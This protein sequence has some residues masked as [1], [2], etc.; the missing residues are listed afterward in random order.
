MAAGELKR[1]TYKKH[2]TKFM[3]KKTNKLFNNS[4][5]IL[6][7][8]IEITDRKGR[9]C[10]EK[11]F[12]QIKNSRN[13][14][15]IYLEADDKRLGNKQEIF[16]A[17]YIFLALADAIYKNKAISNSL[18]RKELSPEYLFHFAGH[19]FREIGQ[20]NRA[21]DAYLRSGLIGVTNP[22]PSQLA[23]RSFARAKMLFS[24]VGENDKSDELHRME[25]ETRRLFNKRPKKSFLTIWKITSL[26]G[27]SIKRWFCCIII[28]T[29]FFTLG[30]ELL[31]HHDFLHTAKDV[32]WR[33]GI[34]SI[35]FT[36]VTLSTLGYGDIIPKSA[37]SQFFV[38]CNIIVGYIL[39]GIGLTILGKKILRQ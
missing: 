8:P 18:K 33:K 31:Y 37:L 21:A 11:I 39:L 26:Y 27:T 10:Y 20:L 38:L 23:I 35:Y 9:V 6:D 24:D 29:I 3:I 7:Q 36:I 34:S 22:E 32:Q 5:K 12:N 16:E 1:W 25:W 15:E 28:F 19:V 17:A 2:G 13:A 30:Y 14:F 4:L